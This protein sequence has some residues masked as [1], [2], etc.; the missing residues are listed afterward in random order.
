MCGHA[1]HA[2]Q[3]HCG[4]HAVG[5][6]AVG[7]G[8]VWHACQLIRCLFLRE[9]NGA[10]EVPY[11]EACKPAVGEAPDNTPYCLGIDEAGR[12]AMLGHM[13]YG[14]AWCPVDKKEELATMGFMGTQARSFGSRVLDLRWMAQLSVLLL[15]R[16][17]SKMLTDK[18]RSTLLKVMDDC[19]WLHWAVDLCSPDLISGEMLRQ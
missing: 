6:C 5:V 18:N 19:E 14:I 15:L 17:D 16:A 13:T 3:G 2:E 11:A 1:D 7:V 9:Q 8:A 12:G 4:A 10:P